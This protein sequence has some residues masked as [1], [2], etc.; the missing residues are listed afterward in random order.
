MIF[1]THA[2]LP[3]GWARDVRI[4]VADGRVTQV[5]TGQAPKAD[6]TRVDTLLP[7]LANLHCH[8]FQRAMAGMT[9]TRLAGKDSFWT[10]RDLMYR[11]TAHL[12]PAH[13]E[14]IAA[15]VFLEMQEAGFASVGEF[16]YLHHQPDG[17]PYDNLGELS[18]RIAAAA[19]QTG[20]GLT[21]LPVLYTYGEA[22]QQPLQAGQARFGNGV[23]RFGALV[24]QA[25]RAVRDLSPDCRV[26]IAP[27]SLRATA[28]AELAEVLAD[29]PD[30]PV[31]IHLAEQPKEVADVSAW[32]GAR[33]VEWL[34]ANAEVAENWCLIHATHMTEGETA[35]M[36][37]SGAVAGLCPVTE[38]NLGDGPF[39][40]P[41]YLAAGGRFGI[42]SDSNVLISLTEELRTLEYSQRLRDLARNV[43]V[44]GEGSV[45]AALY[46][47]AARGGAQALGR[48]R[49]EIAV[50][51][52]ADL[53]AID[54]QDP[55]LCALRPDQ[56]LDGLAFA[57]KDRVV[58]DLWSA[59]RH[60]VTGGRH[61]QRDRIVAGYR[62]A[63]AEVMALL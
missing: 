31:H 27:H 14:A 49:G 20:I 34:L 44:A 16:H 58:T 1:A 32:L 22:G 51:E 8:S 28:P 11:F 50:G 13:I 61:R 24:E 57:A 54:S 37:R 60:A 43:M 23:A 12:T 4:T 59:G 47:G 38:A 35:A 53:V 40:G 46:T 42:G 39:N 5:E 56:L 18:A 15:F 52:W 26:G 33:P 63:M 3:Q 7:A 41:G 17:T 55:A 6:D 45:G 29:H 48:G 62:R 9:E 2:K 21:H 25:Q 10:W 19:A 30:V 36:A